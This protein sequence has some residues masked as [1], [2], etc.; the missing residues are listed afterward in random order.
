MVFVVHHRDFI[1]RAPPAVLAAQKNAPQRQHPVAGFAG[2]GPPTSRLGWKKGDRALLLDDADGNSWIMK[3]F[4][5]GPKPQ[6]RLEEFTAA[7]ASTIMS[8]AFSTSMT[9][10]RSGD[11]RR[12][13]LAVT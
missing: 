8:D 9:D 13:A 4:Q 10:D 2:G 7:A 6:R 11:G 1:D 3:G 5:L 12:Q